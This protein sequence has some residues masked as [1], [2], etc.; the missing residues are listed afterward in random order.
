MRYGPFLLTF[1]VL[2]A[3][4][5]P[6]RAA[7]PPS[8]KCREHGRG[9]RICTELDESALSRPGRS[10]TWRI[11][12]EGEAGPIQVR[13]HNDSPAVVRVKGGD[14][15]VIHMGYRLHRRV[16]RKVISIGPGA[17]RLTARPYSAS[18]KQ[19][20][21]AIAAA[22][23][24]LLARIEAEFIAGRARLS[25]S[26]DYFAAE[27]EDLLAGTEAALLQALSYTELAALRDYVREEFRQ[28]RAAL[29]ASRTKEAATSAPFPSQAVV[30]S[31]HLTHSLYPVATASP[32]HGKGT[33]PKERADSMLGGILRSIHRLW[34]LAD[35]NEMVTDLC[36][37]SEPE[38]GA[39]VRLRPRR[40]ETWRGG[41]TDT[42]I[43]NL[44]RGIYV[45]HVR[46]GLRS[47]VAC[48]DPQT[49]NLINLVDDP[50]RILAC[51]LTNKSCAQRGGACR[52]DR[53]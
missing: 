44:Y 48:T 41:E 3:D 50:G 37:I 14:D 4:T 34:E 31:L 29:D 5:A 19:E 35:Q 21:A 8:P 51:N 47:V 15:Q 32:P 16:K 27:V 11:W 36:I 12:V 43:Q 49:C 39:T 42:E 33:V 28:A 52:G 23:A 2:L 18:P 9:V 40:A 6:L 17:A 45:Y 20:A 53:P 1:L 30:A 7:G 38:R 24:P 26:P 22:L 10:T 46:K 13:L 25:A